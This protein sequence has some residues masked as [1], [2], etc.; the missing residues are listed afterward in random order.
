[1]SLVVQNAESTNPWIRVGV[2]PVFSSLI[3]PILRNHNFIDGSEDIHF[4]FSISLSGGGEAGRS[5]DFDKPWLA[6]VVDEDVEAI[7]LEAVLIVD[8]NTLDTL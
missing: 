2:C 6:V 1:M 5:I 4:E 3:S 8:D 7:K